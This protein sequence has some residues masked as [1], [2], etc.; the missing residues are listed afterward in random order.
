M[1]A[2]ENVA[3]PLE[4]AGQSDARSAPRVNCRRLGSA[5]GCTILSPRRPGG[6]QQRVAF[7]RALAPG[8]PNLLAD[9]PTG[10][11]DNATGQQIV[12]L[13]FGDAR[14]PRHHAG[15]CDA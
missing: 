3:V 12:D 5:S 13:L 4:L 6:E 8:Q 15:A 11:L 1:T 9:E 7:A 2:L 10:N 14:D